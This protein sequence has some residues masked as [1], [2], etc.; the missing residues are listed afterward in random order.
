MKMQALREVQEKLNNEMARRRG[1]TASGNSGGSYRTADGVGLSPSHPPGLAV[2]GTPGV[3][4]PLMFT[5]TPGMQPV[6]VS[7][8]ALNE[9]LRTLE[10]P[11]L[12]ECSALEF[13][14][15]MAV[16]TPYNTVDVRPQQYFCSV[17]GHDVGS[18]S[19][20]S[21]TRPRKPQVPTAHE[22]NNEQ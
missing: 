5:G 17:V 10:L 4:Q 8:E 19:T 7:G 2:T 15:W 21:S 9:S 12:T 13:G 11:K 22:W 20:P 14:D 3:G 18:T 16:I 6:V 1:V